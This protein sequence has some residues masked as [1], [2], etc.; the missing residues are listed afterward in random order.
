[1][2]PWVKHRAVH[3][4]LANRTL[5]DARIQAFQRPI[6]Y[7]CGGLVLSEEDSQLRHR[8]NN[9]PRDSYDPDAQYRTRING[10]FAYGGPLNQ[11][12]GHFMSETI[13]RVLPSK[14]LHSGTPCVFVTTA[15]ERKVTSFD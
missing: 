4:R 2:P 3:A 12:F 6:T 5:H 1:M 8:R 13:H 7:Y 11:H 14:L 9:R 15:Q 10:E